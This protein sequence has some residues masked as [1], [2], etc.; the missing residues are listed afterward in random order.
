MNDRRN[1]M[2]N[3]IAAT[4]LA[5]ILAVCG[6]AAA[7]AAV[8]DGTLNSDFAQGGLAP[9]QQVQFFFD[10][11]NYCWYDTGWHGP[12]WYWCGYAWNNGNGWGGGYGFRGWSRPGHD[13]D[14]DHGHPGWTPHTTGGNTPHTF[15]R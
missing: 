11:Y 8:S 12:G 14:H 1:Q 7:D 15:N 2:R 5:T 13:H 4:T 3:A 9:L 6:V 10:G